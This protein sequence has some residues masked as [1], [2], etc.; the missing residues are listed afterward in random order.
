MTFHEYDGEGWHKHETLETALTGCKKS[1]EA[2][3]KCAQLDYNKEWP[4][5]VE[6]ISVYEAPN[7]CEYP[8]ED[9]K[10]VARMHMIN[11]QEAEPGTS[12]DFYCEFELVTITDKQ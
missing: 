1:L 8:D 2:A 9:G 4:D 3:K 6:Q 5:W 11:K 7:D 10:Q 12:C